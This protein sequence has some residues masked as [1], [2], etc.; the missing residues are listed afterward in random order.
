MVQ[1]LTS[2]E[3]VIGVYF[4]AV[5]CLLLMRRPRTLL[6]RMGLAEKSDR[7]LSMLGIGC[8]GVGLGLGVQIV[9]PLP[10]LLRT[11]ILVV[12]GGLGV[13]TLLWVQYNDIP[14]RPSA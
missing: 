9:A 13:I 11:V 4:M 1:A 6:E 12:A 14:S 10:I 8:G 5:A 7:Q 2:V 3:A